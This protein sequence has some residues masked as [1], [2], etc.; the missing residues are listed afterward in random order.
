MTITRRN[1]FGT[2][3]FKSEN[4]MSAL[5]AGGFQKSNRFECQ[6]QPPTSLSVSSELTRKVSGRIK[7]VSLPDRTLRS[8]ANT[9]IYGP[10]HDIVQGQTYASLSL[11]F[12]LSSDMIE[13]TY[14]EEWQKTTYDY[15]TYNINYYKEYVGGLT[16]FAL[17]E[18]DKRR[19]G[20]EVMEAFPDTIGAVPFTSDANTA[21]N[22]FT[23]GF[24]FRYYRNIGYERASGDVPYE[25]I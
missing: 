12:Y 11:G 1:N 20:V 5:A 14:F 13:R 24:K 16:I 7:E 3:P 9:N 18:Q 22:S 21:A 4:M 19:Y 25:E 10:T 8:V 17:D 6:I 23:V 15:I 2:T